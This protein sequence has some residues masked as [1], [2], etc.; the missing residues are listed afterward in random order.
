MRTCLL[1]LGLFALVLVGCLPDRDYT[2]YADGDWLGDELSSPIV[3]TFGA[4]TLILWQHGSTA[5]AALVAD[6]S[7]SPVAVP[8]GVELRSATLIPGSDHHL[9]VWVDEDRERV[10]AQRLG[11]GGVEVG[12]P[13]ELGPGHDGPPPR[14]IFDG[15]RFW[16]V[17]GD[18]GDDQPGPEVLLARVDAAG[19]LIDPSPIAIEP[20]GAEL[21]SA[22]LAAI[23]DRVWVVWQSA[24]GVY[25]VGLSSDGAVVVPRQQLMDG[26]ATRPTLTSAG[27]E[28]LLVGGAL[29]PEGCLF[30][31]RLGPDGPLDPQRAIDL[32]SEIPDLLDARPVA[33]TLMWWGDGYRLLAQV[34]DAGFPC[35]KCELQLHPLD[36]DGTPR[37]TSPT[38][39]QRAKAWG[40]RRV[41]DELA[42]ARVAD[43]VEN[44]ATGAD[45]VAHSELLCERWPIEGEL[46]G[47]VRVDRARYTLQGEVICD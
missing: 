4:E 13:V 36:P 28:A 25:G 14:G 19:Q 35:E 38:T 47:L 11:P 43:T 17:W 31:R 2:C 27:D 41:G 32:D 39:R 3:A 40:V 5:Q 34:G 12:E 46:Y 22:D 10:T 45:G 33:I 20:G 16:V 44:L 21:Y 23:G 24:S 29:D 8:A 18:Y 42:V 15:E 1:G 30:A 37:S 26:D 7:A 9:L 6:G